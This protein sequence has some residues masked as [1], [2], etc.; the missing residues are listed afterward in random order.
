MPK[1][2]KSFALPTNK[3]TAETN[4]ETF[5]EHRPDVLIKSLDAFKGH[6]AMGTRQGGLTEIE[7][8]KRDTEEHDVMAQ[9]EKGHSVYITSNPNYAAKKLRYNYSSMTTPSSTIDFDFD[10]KEKTVKKVKKVLGNFTKENYLSKRIFATSQDGVQIP[11]SLVYR[12]DIKRDGPAPL[13]LYGY[14]SYGYSIDPKFSSSRLSLLDRGFIFAIAHIRGSSTMGEQWYL[15]GKYLKKKNTFNDFIAAADHL[16]AQNYTQ[17]GRI[18]AMGG[19]AGGLLMG[20]VINE[21]PELFHGVVAS[22]PFVDVLTTM[23]DESIPLTTN[24]YEE[25]GNPNFKEY[26]TYIKSYPPYDNIKEQPYP[27]LLVTSGLHDS[28]VQY[29]EPTKWVAKLRDHNTSENLIIL[30]TDLEAGHSGQSGR[31]K[32]L[33]DTARNYAFLIH[34]F[35]HRDQI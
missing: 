3:K 11:I 21:R 12:K 34:L 1:T 10:T 14:G 7:I 25:W 9:P 33:E 18:Y 35:K 8:I 2:L 16:I 13:L 23:L 28:Q 20:A 32:S 5:L 29:W 31:F 22:V 19:S 24:E 15:D 17:K 6:L 4:W 26:Y 30:H 27:H